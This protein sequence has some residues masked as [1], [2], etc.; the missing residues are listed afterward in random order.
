S[1]SPCLQATSSSLDWSAP[2][3]SS[4]ARCPV[5]LSPTVMPVTTLSQITDHLVTQ[6]Q[7]GP[8][9]SPGS[10]RRIESGN[11]V[12]ELGPEPGE[13][14]SAP[15]DDRRGL[16]AEEVRQE[17]LGLGF[18]VDLGTQPTVGIG[19]AEP[20]SD[21]R[22]PELHGLSGRAGMLGILGHLGEI[23]QN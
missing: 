2:T 19:L 7:Q 22:S 14:E 3:A 20:G 21:P 12:I 13:V 17:H 1:H 11:E 6:L 15:A 9:R 4:K 23:G 8:L 16:R 5:T 18:D 10:V